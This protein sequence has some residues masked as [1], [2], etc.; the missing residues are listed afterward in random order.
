MAIFP[1]A[2][3]SVAVMGIAI[4]AGKLVG[5]AW[6]K[7]NWDNT[8]KKMKVAGLS[9]VIVSML[10][11]SVGIFGY[12]TKASAQLTQGVVANELQLQSID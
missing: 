4:E 3:F 12:L 5:A 6:L 9:L 8:T 2:A 1:A 7:R 11:T 10:L